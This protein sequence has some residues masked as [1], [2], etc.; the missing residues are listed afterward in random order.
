MSTEDDLMRIFA[1]ER[2]HNMME[3]LKVPEDMPIEQKMISRMLESAQTKVEGHNFD[4]RKHLLQYDDILNRQRNAIYRRRRRI[5]ELAEGRVLDEETVDAAQTEETDQP[6]ERQY[7]SLKEMILDMIEGE[8]EFVV[9][10]HTNSQ[11]QSEYSD[12]DED[13]WNIVEIIETM[14]TILPLSQQEIETVEGFAEQKGDGKFA[15]VEA[16]DQIVSFLFEK[17]KTEYAR[18]EEQIVGQAKALGTQEAED[19]AMSDEDGKKLM[20]QVEKNLLLRAIDTLWVEHLVTIDHLRKSIGLRGY[21]QRD[22][23]IEYKRE[24]YH[25]FNALEGSIQK[26]VVYSFFKVSVGL[27]LAQTVMASEKLSMQ[28]AKKSNID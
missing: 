12:E 11:K 9:S 27:Q 10:F 22:P 26:E 23:L 7:N 20:Q 2:M 8:I 18:I 28:G 6:E 4:I 24:T 25:L 16:R 15:A 3:R 19:A 14:K 1:G 21:A 13:S 5:L 17:A